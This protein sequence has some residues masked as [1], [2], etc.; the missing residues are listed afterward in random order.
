LLTALLIAHGLIAVALLGA[1]THQVAA[2]F[3]RGAVTKTRFVGRYVAV[4]QERFTLAIAVLY[5]LVVALGSTVY[6]A[7]RV[8]VRI[9]FEEMALGWAI[10]LFELKEHAGAV[11]LGLLPLYV[12]IWRSEFAVSHAHDCRVISAMIAAIVWFNFIVGHILNN[13]R[14]LS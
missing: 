13:I 12:H 9:P 11:G 2:L 7:Y 10:G 8:D 14:G 1:V 5:V 6:P 4:R 3:A